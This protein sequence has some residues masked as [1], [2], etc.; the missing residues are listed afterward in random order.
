MGRDLRLSPLA[1]ALPLATHLAACFLLP[2]GA[3]PLAQP[4]TAFR[5]GPL[6]LLLPRLFLTFPGGGLRRIDDPERRRPLAAPPPAV[7]I[8]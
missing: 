8:A 1:G 6:L 5:R 7:V 3:L 4:A 2:A